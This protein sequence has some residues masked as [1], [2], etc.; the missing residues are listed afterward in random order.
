MAKIDDPKFWKRVKTK[1]R[2]HLVEQF[3]TPVLLSGTARISIEAVDEWMRLTE[4][5]YIG[6]IRV[7]SDRYWTH[8]ARYQEVNTMD[9]RTDFLDWMYPKE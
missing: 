7:W 3:A 4:H 5:A 2:K 9:L 1:C 8:F 6:G